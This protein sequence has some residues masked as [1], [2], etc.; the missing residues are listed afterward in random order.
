MIKKYYIIHPNG[1]EKLRAQTRDDAINEFN[2]HWTT[3]VDVE[4]VKG[5]KPLSRRL[6]ETTSKEIINEPL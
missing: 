3:T 4:W 5:K 1:R 2:S 6:I